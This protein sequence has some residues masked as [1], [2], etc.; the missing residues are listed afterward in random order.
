MLIE[1]N[2]NLKIELMVETR[3]LFDEKFEPPRWENYELESIII[4]DGWWS[5]CEKDVKYLNGFIPVGEH[6]D[7]LKCYEYHINFQGIIQNTDKT[8]LRRLHLYFKD[9]YLANYTLGLMY[10][11]FE[12]K[13]LQKLKDIL[14]DSFKI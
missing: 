3:Q 1:K 11:H 14:P 13:E 8:E 2:N 9:K 10:N 5:C 4:D 7:N 6:V 12:A